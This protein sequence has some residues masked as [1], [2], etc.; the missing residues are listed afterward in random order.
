VRVAA[1]ICIGVAAVI[2]TGVVGYLAFQRTVARGLLPFQISWQRM[3]VDSD[4]ESWFCGV[5]Q[6]QSLQHGRATPT[7]GPAGMTLPSRGDG[8]P[9][10]D[11]HG[12]ISLSQ[13]R[14]LD[15]LEVGW[16]VPCF[17][18]VY[19]TYNE[20]V[21]IAGGRVLRGLDLDS[22][23][24]LEWLRPDSGISGWGYTI[25]PTSVEWRP[26]A[27]N[28]AAWTAAA[29]CVLSLPAVWRGSHRS[30]RRRAGR[31]VRCGYD[32][33]GVTICPECGATA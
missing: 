11:T 10:P 19:A 15:W 5:Y 25:L 6:G 1:A 26:F 8:V 7:I 17:V 33:R 27:L 31:C 28:L 21:Q 4:G 20:D 23:D 30:I 32:I 18:A 9:W 29:W 14:E 24:A 3:F 13:Y 12:R 16:P 22:T 2:G